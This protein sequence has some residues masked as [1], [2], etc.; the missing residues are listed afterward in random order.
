MQF[1]HN[2][3]KCAVGKFRHRYIFYIST[4]IKNLHDILEGVVKCII[5]MINI[6]LTTGIR[7]LKR[8]LLNVFLGQFYLCFNRI[9]S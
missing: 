8:T 3:L 4:E 5:N 1:A 6:I 9:Y 7:Y 2:C